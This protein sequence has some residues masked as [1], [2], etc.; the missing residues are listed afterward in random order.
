MTTRTARRI[1]ASRFKA[2]CLALLD[3]VAAHRRTIVVTKRGK[4]VAR[5]VPV[6]DEGVAAD[7]RGSILSQE[8]IVRPLDEDWD[9]ES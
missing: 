7:L 4:A 6:E 5:V 1:P 9:V 8:D 2:E 3:D